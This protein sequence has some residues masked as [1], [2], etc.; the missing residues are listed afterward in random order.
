MKKIFLYV[1][2]N[3]DFIA[4]A[5]EN[6]PGIISNLG[7]PKEKTGTVLN[8]M[9]V[10]LFKI[11]NKKEVR[12]QLELPLD[13][14]IILFVGWMIER[15]GINYLF[16]AAKNLV[17]DGRDYLFYFIGD[18]ALYDGFVKKVK[19]ENLEGNLKFVGR[20]EHTEIPMWMNG[21]DIFVFPSLFEGRPNAV[22]E[23]M[24]CGAPVIAT[25][26]KGI[27][28]EL[29]IDGKNGFMVPS[30]DSKSIQ[31]KIKT[32]IDNPKKLERF[33]RE[34]KEFIDKKTYS[35][36]DCAKKYIAIYESLIS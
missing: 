25:D 19:E 2:K 9:R 10:D 1:Y 6:H 33:S 12:K 18:G 3:A 22:A 32:L 8:G 29:I 35:W 34:G 15:K 36:Q 30:K 23:A 26:I 16:E 24:M 4:S 14:K 11:R 28:D 13:K 17:K 21:C 7:I 31:E 20:K 5:N 27:R